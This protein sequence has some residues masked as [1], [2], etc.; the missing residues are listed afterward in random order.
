[1]VCSTEC[2]SA[3]CWGPGPQQCLECQHVKFNN[4]CLNSCKS[5]P[6]IYQSDV[7]HCSE[8]HTECRHSCTGPGADNCSECM[9]VKDGKFCVAQCPESKYALNG[10]CVPCHETC[11]GCNG[12]DDTIGKDGC[13]TC[14][15]AIINGDKIERCLRKD[16]ECPGKYKLQ[17]KKKKHANSA[18]IYFW[19]FF[20][21]YCRGLLP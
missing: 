19:F 20:F 8:C 9:N 5:S 11:I 21:H 6:N 17:T 1:M 14:D 16:E 3:G 10:I 15:K 13:I 7:K 12:P 18:L 4:T 2:T